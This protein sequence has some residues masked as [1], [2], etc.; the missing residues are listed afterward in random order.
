MDECVYQ[1]ISEDDL[2]KRTGIQKQI[3]NTIYQ[4]MAVKQKNPEYLEQ[5][6]S[7]LMVPDY[8]HYLLTGKKAMEY[9]I[10]TTTQLVNPDT[11]VWDYELIEMLGYNKELFGTLSEPGTVVGNLREELVKEI[12]FDLEVVLP[13]SHDTGSAVMAVPSTK[14]DTIY[15]SSGTWSL[16]GIERMV[17]DCSLKVRMLILQTKVVIIIVSAILKTLWAYG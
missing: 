8:F 9:T 6:T 7:L 12:G 10:A 17:A 16:M 11:K 3:F 13:A 15:I 2:Y 5:A 14:K 1:V 4:L